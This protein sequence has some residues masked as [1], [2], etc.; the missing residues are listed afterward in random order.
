MKGTNTIVLNEAT[1]I[2][3]VTYWLLN[4]VL[5]PDEQGVEVLEVKPAS[6]GMGG[7]PFVIEVTIKSEGRPAP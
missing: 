7:E 5:H 2:E 4:K 3:A 1:M 6:K